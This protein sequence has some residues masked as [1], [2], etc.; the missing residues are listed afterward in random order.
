LLKLFAQ[1]LIIW[2]TNKFWT[3][4]FLSTKCF[5]NI[6]LYVYYRILHNYVCTQVNGSYFLLFRCKIK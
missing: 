4:F 2:C 6:S 1:S 3:M 5:H